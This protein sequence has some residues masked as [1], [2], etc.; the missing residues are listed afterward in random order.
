MIFAF[1]DLNKQVFILGSIYEISVSGNS[2]I[3][4]RMIND[5]SI[6]S[7]LN[8]GNQKSM[9]KDYK[10]VVGAWEDYIKQNS[11]GEEKVMG[12]IPGLFGGVEE[13][14]DECDYEEDRSCGFI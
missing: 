3:V 11:S 14:D 8:Y 2:I 10:K 4:N 12:Y 6:P 7:V 9:L 1:N 5:R 13:E